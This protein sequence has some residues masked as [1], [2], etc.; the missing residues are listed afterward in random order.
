[1]AE[2]TIVNPSVNM[3][4]AS[5]EMKLYGN[6][7]KY[8]YTSE[9]PPTDAERVF[10]FLSGLNICFTTEAQGEMEREDRVFLLKPNIISKFKMMGYK[11]RLETSYP[12]LKAC[13]FTDSLLFKRSML[14]YEPKHEDISAVCYASLKDLAYHNPESIIFTSAVTGAGNEYIC[15]WE[16]DFD[17]QT[18][19]GKDYFVFFSDDRRI[20]AYVS[21]G[22]LV[23]IGSGDDHIN[24]ISALI[25]SLKK[26]NFRRVS[27]NNV[28]RNFNP[29]I[30][31]FN[32]SGY[33]I[34]D[35]SFGSL[36]V[37]MPS[38]WYDKVAGYIHM[39]IEKRADKK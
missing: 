2:I 11:N 12:E 31:P 21:D 39:N 9:I 25:P 22:I 7:V 27:I 1:M 5:M 36:S 33:L 35:Y 10:Y 14:R 23:T 29:W 28:N 6:N 32:S 13:L 4:I 30:L 34:N 3:R 20:E 15:L 38:A 37:A 24:A 19:F 18:T 16:T 17:L 26:F 8:A